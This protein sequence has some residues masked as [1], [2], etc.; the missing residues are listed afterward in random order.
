[1]PLF[2]H[3]HAV[4]A[5]LFYVKGDGTSW[6]RHDQQRHDAL[7]VEQLRQVDVIHGSDYGADDSV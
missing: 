3:V 2:N 5:S 6:S 7:Y 4:L 1:M